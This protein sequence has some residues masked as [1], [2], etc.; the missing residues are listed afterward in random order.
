MDV[1]PVE[2]VHAGGGAVSCQ[3]TI[4]N[5]LS[6]QLSLLLPA[7]SARVDGRFLPEAHFGRALHDDVHAP[8]RGYTDCSNYFRIAVFVLWIPHRMARTGDARRC[9]LASACL[10]FNGPT[11]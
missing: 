11:P 8:D 6:V 4:C 9:D 5:I 7:R 2:S 1:A 3:H 10:L